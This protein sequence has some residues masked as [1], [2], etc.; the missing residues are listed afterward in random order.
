MDAALEAARIELAGLEVRWETERGLVE[1]LL[2]LRATL[3]QGGKPLD[4]RG[5][6]L[7]YGE[8]VV[9]LIA[10]RCTEA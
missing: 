2:A 3:R 8:D 1:R 9:D 7:T 10:S 5:I 4:S 6:P